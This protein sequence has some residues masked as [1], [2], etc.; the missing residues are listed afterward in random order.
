MSKPMIRLSVMLK[1]ATI[2]ELDKIAK[3]WNE[4]LSA[5]MRFMIEHYL[6]FGVKEKK[7]AKDNEYSG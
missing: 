4:S 2:E 1:L 3:D 6:K 5:L 7:G